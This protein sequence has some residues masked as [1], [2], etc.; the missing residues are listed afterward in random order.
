MPHCRP[1]PE[2]A[3]M[4][5][6][7]LGWKNSFG[8]GKGVD[9]ITSGFEGAWTPTRRS[10]TTATLETLL[11]YEW[12]LTESP[13]GAKQWTPKDVAGDRARTRT[14]RRSGTRR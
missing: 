8:S 10:G 3:P 12:E 14:T 13:A 2:G 7:G 9:T 11:D 5:Q 1:E 4:E 6:Q